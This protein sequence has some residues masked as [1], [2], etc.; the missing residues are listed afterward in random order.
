M[1]SILKL[2]NHKTRGLW[3][4]VQQ[5]MMK[6]IFNFM[7]K[8][9]NN[10]LA[11]HK[12]LFK[13]SLSDSQSCSLYLHPET[14]QQVVSSCRS[15]LEDG[16]YTWRHISVLLFIPNSVSSIQHCLV[17][18]GL[19][20]SPSPSLITGHSL[21]PDLVL[22][23]PD[24]CLYVLGLTVGF[25]TNTEVNNNRKATKYRPLFLDLKPQYRK[26]NFVII[27]TGT[28]GI[29]EPTSD[30]LL[31][32]MKELGIDNSAQKAI[33]N[34]NIAERCTYYVYCRRNTAWTN[35]E[36]LN[37]QLNFS[38]FSLFFFNLICFV[39][40]SSVYIRLFIVCYLILLHYFLVQTCQ[41]YIAC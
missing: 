37:F 40:F 17:Y 18:A 41:L 25:E 20:F 24:N 16:R 32:M 19:P 36:L 12:N 6:N 9:L 33:K 21:R 15:Y 22:I 27:S 10:T 13:W 30:S 31:Y 35:P 29:L 34:M 23:S 11:T 26:I 28:L 3:S 1:S 5:N 39:F 2:S 7:I 4:K 8:Y 38:Y 14:L